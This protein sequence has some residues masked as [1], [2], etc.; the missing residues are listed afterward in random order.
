MSGKETFTIGKVVKLLSAS[1][2][3]LTVS[4]VRYLES[5][6]LLSPTRSK[7][8]YRTYTEDDVKRL[9]RILRMQQ[10]CFY[11]LNVIKEKLDTLDAG[12]ELEELQP[13]NRPE[14]SEEVLEKMHMLE[15]VPALIN[16][17][18]S[19]IRSLEEAGLLKISKSNGGRQLVDGRDIPLIR[20]AYE[21]KRYGIDTRFLKAHVQRAN[22]EVVLFKQVLASAIGRQASFDD[23][24]TLQQFN[25]TLDRLLALN[26]T[27][28]DCIVRRE[29][30]REFNHPSAPAKPDQPKK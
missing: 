21:L 10:T 14:E 1:Y 16:I 11:P 27:V 12:E 13:E 23:P 25:A 28:G 29:V 22:R 5:E 6:G 3:D 30:L 17:P 2:P 4:K 26:N 8:G 24:K 15:D 7:G 9:E 18:V 20:A 19:F